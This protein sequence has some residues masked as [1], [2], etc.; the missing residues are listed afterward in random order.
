MRRHRKGVENMASIIRDL[1][2][3]IVTVAVVAAFLWYV[4]RP[5]MTRTL[6]DAC[7]KT[8]QQVTANLHPQHQ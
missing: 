7:T 3:R 8:L 6:T 2:V 4:V 1:F 5:I